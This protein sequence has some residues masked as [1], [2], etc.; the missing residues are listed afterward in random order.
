MV[1][2]IPTPYRIP[3]YER[4][5][6]EGDIELLVIFF[7][8]REPDREWDLG[9]SSFHQVFLHERFLSIHGRFIHINPDVWRQLRAF[10]PD[11]VVT[12]GFNPSHLLAYAYARLYGARHVAMTDG[13]Q[14]SEIILSAL[15]RWIRR[16]VYAHTEA[17][18]AASNGS[19]DLYH[20]YGV[21]S[22]RMF[23]SHL[24]ADNEMYFS[25]PVVEKR[26]DFI[27]CGRFV[28]VK[29]PFFALD[30]AKGVALR[31]G[32]RVSVMFVGSGD[33]DSQMRQAAAEAAAW[34]D[35]SFPGFASQQTLPSLY[36]A[37]RIFLFPTLWEPWGVVA[38]EA[39]AAGIP[40]LVSRSAGSAHELIRHGDN[41]YVLP[42]EID[43]WVEAG[44][45]LLSDPVLYERMS[46]C[47]RSLVSAYN[48]GNAARGI[49]MACRVAAGLTAATIP[50]GGEDYRRRRR[51]VIIQR[52][53]T[54]YRIPFFEELH[55]VLSDRG[56]ELNVVYGD[57]TPMEMAKTDSGVLSWGAYIANRYFL[58][59]KLCWQNAAGAVYGADLVVV[60]QENKQLYNYWLMLAHRSV[61]LAFWAH[62]RNFQSGRGHLL[63]ECFKRLV[64]R[65]VD[66]WFAY[67]N[68]SADVVR[69]SGF[70]NSRLTVVNNA[71]DTR[72]LAAQMAIV[73][74][75]SRQTLRVQLGLT[76]KRVGVY[77]DSIDDEKRIPFL[78][79]SALAIH[80]AIPDFAF[81]I[82][83]DGADRALVEAFCEENSWALFLGARKGGE[84]A[85][86]LAISSV[87]L[88]PGPLGLGILDSFVAG[89][90][91]VTTDCRMHGPETA[92]L[93]DGVNGRMTS[94][95]IDAFAAAV[96]ELFQ[97]PDA[98]EKLKA[99]CLASAANYTL[100]NMVRNFADGIERC[101]SQVPQ[102]ERA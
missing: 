45:R 5:A 77:I 58:N 47:S 93:E 96:C 13:T 81:L 63:R 7:S 30:V 66:W 25:S 79:E 29:N 21:D 39:C 2:N 20:A 102:G 91:M 73:D 49:A 76:G 35:V 52:R 65:R 34:V 85:E 71:I 9:D 38:N 56:I 94:D 1:T 37:A 26:F 57:S 12:T 84:K 68:A 42:L 99:G 70:P 78:L 88:S 3:I 98:L 32:R 27:F 23:K 69:K 92:Y 17:F 64:G 80:Q 31:L 41:G 48:Y 101:L 86:V 24:C 28:R 50:Y 89:V 33:L 74:Q 82:V 90:P 67:T 10:A 43:R 59:G 14:V 8:G 16:R 22:T 95:S 18:I 61:R 87:M 40:V 11:V 54:H 44:A 51:V 19:F 100:E 60:T 97:N 55:E 62:G 6:K 4:L 53:M 36:G 46:A 75:H 72:A 15:H 83:G